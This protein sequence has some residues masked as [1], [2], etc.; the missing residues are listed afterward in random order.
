MTKYRV[1]M[2]EVHWREVFI[3][4]NSPENALQKVEE[5]EGERG[6]TC[7]GYSL[8]PYDWKVEEVDG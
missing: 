5:G 7:Y 6:D 2:Q 3:E 1:L 8:G 4:A